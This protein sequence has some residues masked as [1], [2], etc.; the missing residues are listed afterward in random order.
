MSDLPYPENR[1]LSTLRE[2]R[3]QPWSRGAVTNLWD[4]RK[5]SPML[6]F[7][8]PAFHQFRVDHSDRI[9]ISGVQEKVSVR[10]ENGKLVPTESDG[11]Y[12]L[13]PIP[14]MPS[15]ESRE[16]VPANE[17]LSMRIAAQVFGIEVPP[18]GIVF[19]NDSSPA[20]IIKRFDRNP[21]TGEK[22]PQEDFCQLSNRSKATHGQNYKYDGSYEELGRILK[23]FC[24]AY[25]IEIEKLFRLI[26]F[27]YLIGN[28]DAHFKNFSLVPT[29][30][31]H[32]VLSPAYDL[33]STKLHLP[34][35]SSTALDF[36]ADD[37]ETEAFQQNAF[38]SGADFLE[39]AD[40]FE[41]KPERARNILHTIDS[42]P[43]N[44]EAIVKVSLLSD[45]ARASYMEVVRDRSKAVLM[46][47]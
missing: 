34:N 18:N 5:V 16:Q 10:I 15:L 22:Y 3:G 13:K 42:F 44:A 8:L 29:P 21:A 12:I 45:E 39:L 24:G 17:H 14:S 1:C 37:F 26:V 46:G 41:M 11:Q 9:S 7:D 28:G 43:D 32:F 38:Y 2:T 25:A 36:F 27:N 33:L 35:E 20:Y 19:F 40:R 47:V 31:S 4:N 6:D 23:Q 30:D